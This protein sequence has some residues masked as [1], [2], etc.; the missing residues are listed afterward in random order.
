[1][2]RHR[3]N[4]VDYLE[5]RLPLSGEATGIDWDR[6]H[7]DVD[8]LVPGQVAVLARDGDALALRIR[9]AAGEL[10]KSAVNGTVYGVR[11]EKGRRIWSRHSFKVTA[12]AAGDATVEGRQLPRRWVDAASEALTTPL[13]LGGGARPIL[14]WDHFAAGR[15]QVLLGGDGA[16]SA[17]GPEGRRARTDLVRLMDTTSGILSIQEALQHDRGLRLRRQDDA[18]TVA[19]ADLAGPALVDHPFAAMQAE[20]PDANAATPEPLAAAAPA[21]FW[22]ARFATL[23]L[24]LRLLGEADRWVTPLVQLLQQNPEDRRLTGRY[25]TELGVVRGELAKILGPAAVGQVAVVG[26]DPYVREGTDVTLIF[27]LRNADFYNAELDRYLR[28]HTDHFE[29]LGR[30][31]ERSTR[32][33]QGVTI[34][35]TRADHGRVRQERAQVGDLGLLSNS[36]R[37]IERVVDAIA[38]RAPR[39]SDSP[40]FRY[41]RARDPGDHQFY[42]FLSDRL[43]AAVIG[44]QQKIQQA[45][46][47]R[48]LAELLVPGYAALLYGWLNGHAP[49]DPKALLASG[50]LG[51]DE[52]RHASGEPITFDPPPLRDGRIPKDRTTFSAWGTPPALTPLIDLPPVTQVSEAEAAAYRDF[53]SGYQMYWRRFIDP[54][55]ISLDITAAEERGPKEEDVDVDV[56][57]LPLI[58]ATDY[59][60][61]ERVVGKQRV[62]VKALDRGLQAVWAVG[63]ESSVRRDLDGILR[64]ATGESDVGVGWVGDWVMVGVE[65]RVALAEL[66]SYLDDRVQRP[67]PA[68]GDDD[69]FTDTELWRRVGASPIYVAAAIK[70]PTMLVATLGGIRKLVNEVAPG[71]VEW[72]EHSKH[73]DLPIVRVGIRRDAPL[74]ARPDMADAVALYYVQTSAAIVV[75]LDPEVLKVVVDRIAAGD[76]QIPGPGAED[77]AQL[78]VDA[79]SRPGDAMWTV[80]SWILQGE[81]MVTQATA[82]RRAEILLR[83][84]HGAEGPGLLTEL[85]YAYFGGTPLSARGSAGFVIDPQGAA[86]PALGTAIHR[87]Y[88][89]LPIRSSPV[90]RLMERLVGF[91]VEVSFDPEPAAAGPDARSLHSHLR[92]RLSGGG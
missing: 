3:A 32:D 5:A 88:P 1:V 10:P 55:A 20:L 70:N 27:Q 57:V 28:Q 80:A 6:L 56:R 71:A 85:G 66:F 23:P 12:D 17:A 60:D 13:Y 92:L 40:D 21:D 45:R 41:M 76:G 4:G 39:L 65:D 67:D 30:G 69:L 24:F 44:P 36:P 46:R 81:A 73:R 89:E 8:L 84:A 68:R 52:L 18:R 25:E 51:K 82:E 61:L 9:S 11:W 49:E 58:D 86:D 53:A 75:G 87:K 37:A 35:S 31:V 43:I 90:E 38:G 33:Y 79:S 77:G 78:I 59:R 34:T 62:A 26:S 63:A 16:A 2:G 22:Y 54:V 7:V 47:E 72:G 83:G 15:L 48:A 14:P 42:A 74:L 91:R 50:L 29:A 19:I 64:A